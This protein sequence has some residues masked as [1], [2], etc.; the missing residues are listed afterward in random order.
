M[1]ENTASIFAIVAM[2]SLGLCGTTQAATID[3]TG[4]TNILNVNNPQNTYIGNGTLQVSGS[5]TLSTDGTQ[6]Q[7]VFQMSGGLITIDGG[8][9]LYNGGWQKGVWTNNLAS[10]NVDGTFNI[11]DGNP[12]TVD[13]LTGAGTFTKGA[14]GSSTLRLGIN[15]GSGTF[16]GSIV[17]PSGAIYLIKTGTGVQTLSG[18]NTYTGGTTNNGGTLKLANQNAVQNSTVTMNGGAVEFDQSVAGNA[19]T[20]GGLAAASA[21]AGYNISLT[22]NAGAAIALTVGGNNANTTYA[23]VL[24]GTGGSLVKNG[25]GTLTLSSV[26]SYTGTTTINAGTLQLGWGSTS[27]GAIMSGGPIT[28]NQGVTLTFAPSAQAAPATGG[29]TVGG[30]ITLSGGVGAVTNKFSLND[31][32]Y[33]LSGGVTGAAGVAQTLAIIQG[34][35]GGGGDREDILFSGVIAD[36]SGGTL[37]VSIDFAGASGTG[38]DVYVALSGQNTFTGPITVNNSKGLTYSYPN[39]GGYFVIGG[40]IIHTAFGPRT[41]YPGS[42]YLGGCNFTNTIFLATGTILDFISSANQTL[43]GTISGGGSVLLEGSGL[44]TLTL[45]GSNTY[46]GATTVSAGTLLVNGSVAAGSAVT[47]SSGATLGG[48]GTVNGA[49]TVNSGATNAPGPAAGVSLGVLNCASNVTIAGTLSI[50]ID[51]T[52]TP[53]CDKLAVTNNL[54][55]TGA[56]LKIVPVGTPTGQVY[57]IASYGGTLGG[58]FTATNGLMAGYHVSTF[59]NRQQGQFLLT[60]FDAVN[61]PVTSYTTTSAVFSAQ[62]FTANTN[63]DVYVYW[64]TT[65]GTNNPSSWTTNAYVGSWTNVGPAI[66][67][68]ATNG[69]TVA[70]DY[71][72]TFQLTNANSDVWAGPSMSFITQPTLSSTLLGWDGGTT[73]IPDNGDGASQGGS[74]TWNITTNN[75]DWG[76]G[77]PHTNWVNGNN[78]A[79]FGGMAGTVTLTNNITVGGLQFYTAGYTVR[80]NILTF[81]TAGNIATY[82][83][84]TIASALSGTVAVAKIG[85]GALTLSG[86]NFLAG[87]FSVQSGTV[88]CTTSWMGSSRSNQTVQVG[89][90]GSPALWTNSVA[91]TIGSGATG[92]NNT[93]NVASQGVLQVNGS[94]LTNTVGNNAATYNTLSIT[95]GGQFTGGSAVTIGFGANSNRYNVGGVGTKVAVSN[96]MIV[97]GGGSSSVIGNTMTVT[98]A[99]LWSSTVYVGRSSSGYNTVSVYSGTMWNMLSSPLIIGGTQAGFAQGDWGG[100]NGIVSNNHFRIYGGTVTNA[101]QVSLGKQSTS[102]NVIGLENS[103]LVVTN[104]GRLFVNGSVIVA[105]NYYSSNTAIS[106]RLLVANGG[107]VYSVGG[108]I[109]NGSYGTAVTNFIQIIGGGSE[110]S[111]ALWSLGGG[112]LTIPNRSSNSGNFIT[113]DGAGVAGGAVMT[114]LSLDIGGQYNSILLTNGGYMF[115]TA[116][117]TI[118]NS[119]TTGNALTIVGGAANSVF[120]MGG[121]TLNIGSGGNY[122]QLLIDAGGTLTNAGTVSVGIN[123]A[124]SNRLT[125]INEG[126]LSAGNMYVGNH[127]GANPIGNA[128]LIANGGRVNLSGAAYVGSFSGWEYA[129]IL[130]YNSLTITNGGR[131]FSSADS[132]IGSSILNNSGYVCANSNNT[133]TIDGSLSGTN[134]TWNLG[135]KNLYVGGVYTGCGSA[136]NVLTVSSGGVVTNVGLVTIGSG[137]GAYYNSMTVTN[138]NVYSTGLTI[139]SASSNNAV[140]VSSNSTWNLGGGNI[141]NGIGAATGNV[142]TVS[143][144]VLTNVNALV[145]SFGAARSN[146]VVLS[147]G[148]Q[149]YA[150]SATITNNNFLTVGVDDAASGACGYLGVSGTLNIANA[151]INIVTNGAPSNAVYLIASYGTLTGSFAATNG[152]PAGWVFS[153]NY[154]GNKIALVQPMPVVPAVVNA[155][156]TNQGAG[157]CTLQ[158]MLTTGGVVNT[159]ICWGTSDAGTNS[160]TNW[161]NSA[162][163]GQVLQSNTFSTVASSLATNVTYW[164]RCFASNSYGIVWAS[165]ANWFNATPASG[166]GVGGGTVGSWTPSNLTVA[167]WYDAADASTV[168]TNGSSVT[169]WLDKS[170]NN[171][172]VAQTNSTQRPSYA[173]SIITFDGTTNFLYNSSPFAYAMGSVDV[174]VVAAVNTTSDK[175]IV[176]ESSTT[177]DT[178]LYAFAQTCSNTNSM[179]AYVRNNTN[180]I[181]FNNTNR[182][183]ATGVFHINTNNLYHWRDSGTSFAGRVAGGSPTTVAY[184]RSGAVTVDRFTIGAISPRPST[185]NGSAFVN[186]GIREIVITG[187]LSDTDRQKMEGYLAWKWG[188]QTNLPATHPFKLGPPSVQGGVVT[189]TDSS[190]LNPTNTPYTGGYVVHT[191]YGSDTFSNSTATSVDVLVVAGGGGGGYFA[192]G[193]G[194]GGLIYS[195]AFSVAANSNY[196]VTVGA[197]GG[198]GTGNG[199]NGANGTNSVFGTITATGGGGG[200]SRTGSNTGQSGSAGGSGGGGSP[201]DSGA[202]GLGG[203][204]TPA[205]Q[206][207][208]GGNGAFYG[209]GAGGGGGAGFAGTNATGNTAG[210]GGNGLAYSISGSNVYYAGGGGG[211]TWSGNPAGAGGL[212][213][214]GPGAS[215]SGSGTAGTPNTGGGGGGSAL[216]TGAQGGSG[217]VIVRYPYS[218]SSVSIQNLTPMAITSTAAVFNALLSCPTTNCDVYVHWGST[219]GTNDSGSWA[220]SAYVGSWTNVASTNISYVNSTLS[221]ST[222]YYYTF[223]AANASTNIWASP[224]WMFVTPASGEDVNF[225]MLIIQ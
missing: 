170:G 100:V 205:G 66:I 75:W 123:G 223:R 126:Q 67:S 3:T 144:S 7:T 97:V 120:N 88:A 16:S 30:A 87:Q 102:G 34:Y 22:N 197:G 224:S 129:R 69:L 146:S 136:G 57:V 184:T 131:L 162:S 105:D 32:K 43:G 10:L 44:G 40:E 25:T 93:F 128:A 80:S 23:G 140:T 53:A 64:G 81:G 151:T 9:G 208:I 79:V 165:P 149:I 174:Y 119:A 116:A 130:S 216:S 8:A 68:F 139:G 160:M 154:Q 215:S 225:T 135:G 55:I 176:T 188:L 20:F 127:S 35:T 145:V 4:T 209:W 50:D 96:A 213:G 211:G 18:T 114:N 192:G 73:N 200:G 13:A 141:T 90:Y 158:G 159:W 84:A 5:V 61:Q 180:G 202:Q 31:T 182:L 99:D 195:N 70:T 218:S 134:S 201:A 45:S 113:A 122:N 65:D 15:N 178:P 112:A 14:A 36:G 142:L 186:A 94:T 150:A 210:R 171:R 203:A 92:T 60:S 33:N 91:L 107:Q 111:T 82:K 49:V 72:F 161:S 62:L 191:F 24:S 83:D 17:N 117:S 185:P 47:V 190:G 51:D 28:I 167:A 164:Y 163:M 183:S 137:A 173:S 179:S 214:G 206:G 187:I 38:Q 106:N 121:Q 147:A 6:A 156:T 212:G 219:D 78:S 26:S 21:G 98:N 71:Y 12:V 217:I 77:Q 101:S 37:G 177:N 95:N 54:M 125:V 104:S 194:A 108:Q 2:L 155:G 169:N 74:G 124:L 41:V 181:S 56:T 220:A 48:T 52:Q 115:A 193:G 59:Y 118:G 27:G 153:T 76:E 110:G 175:R 198:G 221:G 189:Y 19:F 29:Y 166:G 152:L 46:T 63:A 196:T 148:G 85:G 204:A 157:V 109:G 138:A 42:G 86:S 103:M 89:G 39:T 207:N 222:T 58:S 1:K 11:A 199:I 132:Y 172:H 168:L 133:V 143:A